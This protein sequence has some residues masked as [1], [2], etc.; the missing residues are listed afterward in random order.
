MTISPDTRFRQN[1]ENFGTGFNDSYIV[2]STELSRYLELN[3][4][5]T[6]VWD[7]LATPKSLDELCTGM[8][9]VFD[10]DPAICR[11]EISELLSRFLDL[12][13]VLQEG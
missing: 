1:P 4:T 7:L 10:V 13:L 11:A 6:M 8:L 9:A 2:L 3:P 5:A 12:R